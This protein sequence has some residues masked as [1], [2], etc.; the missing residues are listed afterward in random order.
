MEKRREREKM[1]SKTLGNNTQH[2]KT[3]YKTPSLSLSSH[4]S[5]CLQ[6]M[7][8][9]KMWICTFSSISFIC[10]FCKSILSSSSLILCNAK[11]EVVRWSACVQM[12][13]HSHCFTYIKKTDHKQLTG[14][15]FSY[16]CNYSKWSASFPSCPP[17]SMVAV[18]GKNGL[19]W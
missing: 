19:P 14:P 18:L 11:T 12:G 15:G 16:S 4:S 3:G 17:V 10:L 2:Q 13:N 1:V 9:K 5:L 7:T 6:T 8:N